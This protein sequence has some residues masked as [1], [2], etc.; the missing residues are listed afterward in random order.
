MS[1]AKEKKLSC[2]RG[3]GRENSIWRCNLMIYTFLH[4]DF[5]LKFFI[6]TLR[7][8]EARERDLISHL[9]LPT[10]NQKFLEI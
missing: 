1:V 7:G 6:H 8:F 2:L 3:A 4:C 9:Q 5:G 10:C